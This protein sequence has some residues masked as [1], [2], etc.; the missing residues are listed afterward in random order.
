M[1]IV[2][3]S[4][5]GSSYWDLR[6]LNKR[7]IVSSVA[8]FVDH[9]ALSHLTHFH[10]SIINRLINYWLDF[11]LTVKVLHLSQSLNLGVALVDL[12]INRCLNKKKTYWIGYI[13]KRLRSSLGVSLVSLF[14]AFLNKAASQGADD[15]KQ[16]EMNEHSKMWPSMTRLALWTN[17]LPI[18][19]ILAVLIICIRH[20]SSELVSWSFVPVIFLL[21]HIFIMWSVW[22]M[23]FVIL[24]DMR[25]SVLLMHRTVNVGWV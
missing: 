23:R 7:W 2:R 25:L 5:Y 20:W 10:A 13:R 14:H 6:V 18:A 21:L 1:L 15:D 24:M 16:K 12:S 19:V 3:I 8:V 22:R 17:P 9:S 4:D 11:G